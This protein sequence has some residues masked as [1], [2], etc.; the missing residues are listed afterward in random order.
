VRSNVHAR[1]PAIPSRIAP[2]TPITSTTL[3]LNMRPFPQLGQF[4]FRQSHGISNVPAHMPACAALAWFAAVRTISHLQSRYGTAHPVAGHPLAEVFAADDATGQST[5][6]AIFA[7]GSARDGPLAGPVGERE[8]RLLPA[9]PGGAIGRRA[10]LPAFGRIDAENADPRAMDL[11]GVRVARAT[12]PVS[13]EPGLWRTTFDS[14]LHIIGNYRTLSVPDQ[15]E[16]GHMVKMN[17]A[18]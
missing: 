11:E 15:K 3:S 6:L 8:R 1:K 18:D 13:P 7:A 4:R 12:K 16:R 9:P 2:V 17:G 5:A 10:G 14:T